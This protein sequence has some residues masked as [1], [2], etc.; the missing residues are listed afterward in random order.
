[1]KEEKKLC[2]MVNKIFPAK[3]NSNNKADHLKNTVID[4]LVDGITNLERG[5]RIIDRELIIT[6]Q[7]LDILAVD[8]LGQLT[9]IELEPEENEAVI[10][11][12]LEHFDWI[13]H[14]INSVV[15][16]YNKEK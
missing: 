4:L 2:R 12:A 7:T 3:E 8:I 6:K 5:L 14:N 11:R 9:I 1:M 16:K 13:M 15:H 10:L